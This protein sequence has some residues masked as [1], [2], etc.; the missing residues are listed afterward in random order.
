MGIYP[1]EHSECAELPRTVDF[2]WE[3]LEKGKAIQ[4]GSYY[5]RSVMGGGLEVTFATFRAR[6]GGVYTI[7]MR[8]AKDA[9]RI[10]TAHP[11][12]AVTTAPEKLEDV[13]D[14]SLF[15]ARLSKI[16]AGVGLL[17]LSAWLVIRW[18]SGTELRLK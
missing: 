13:A 1:T 2:E 10:N 18:R 8:V 7:L 16:L 15:L 14:T 3:I 6:R 12:V 17:L 11:T 5:P 9:G 4:R